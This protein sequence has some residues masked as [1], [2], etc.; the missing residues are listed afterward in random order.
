[1]KQIDVNTYVHT[2]ESQTGLIYED[3]LMLNCID[4]GQK[5]R[6]NEI[7]KSFNHP[8]NTYWWDNF[9]AVI[10]CNHSQSLQIMAKLKRHKVNF[11]Q[12]PL[13]FRFFF[14]GVQAKALG[15]RKEL[16]DTYKCFYL[17]EALHMLHAHYDR[18]TILEAYEDRSKPYAYVP[19]I[20]IAVD[21]V[22]ATPHIKCN[23]ERE[24]SPAT[25]SYKLYRHDAPPDYKF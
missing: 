21:F 18:I 15:E 25:G 1:M 12:V 13:I 17:G 8:T 5:E 16:S 11:V 23:T 24:V 19:L 4:H 20:P 7:V 2:L 6:F 9:D 3:L 22:N 10:R 14:K